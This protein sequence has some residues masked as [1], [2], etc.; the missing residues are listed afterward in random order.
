MSLSKLIIMKGRASLKCRYKKKKKNNNN[1]KHIKLENNNNNNFIL[2]VKVF[3]Y[4]A[5][6][7]HKIKMSE[8]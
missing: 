1:N 6:G 8:N 7:G 3:R 5:N 4:A 2:S